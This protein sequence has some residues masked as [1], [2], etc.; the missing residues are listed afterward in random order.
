M[1]KP[2]LPAFLSVQGL[3]LSDEE[4][5]LFAKCN[6][7][8]VCL[9]AKGCANVQNPQQLKKLCQEIKEVIGRD[10]VLIAVDQE[11]GRVRRLVEPEFTPLAEQQK[12]TT[13]DLVRQ[14]AFLAAHDLK[15]CGI[16]IDF[17]P[18]LDICY[19]FTSSVLQGRCFAGNEKQI[20][21]LGQAMVDEFIA[22]GICPCV[23]HLPG[24]GRAQSDPHLELPVINAGLDT[25][26]QDFYPFKQLKNAPMGMVAH[27]LLTQI[28]NLRPSSESPAVIHDIIRTEIGFSGFL[29]SDAIMMRALNGS[30]AERAK[31]TLAAGCD[32]VC[33]GN[34]GFSDNVEL[35]D[36]GLILSDEAAERLSAVQKIIRQPLKHSD[37]EQIKN[38]YCATLKNIISYNSEYDATEVL[39]RI[40]E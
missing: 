39:N 24:H 23:K 9:F 18:V 25:L 22:N 30:I 26:Q 16:N 38:K 7:L 31:R 34:T 10:D 15:N 3:Q 37:Y 32:A 14:H 20:A 36:S 40:R 1:T 35:A 17:A 13:P 29:V 11:G 33:L 21:V 5:R 2:I 27:L 19:K 28:D 12:L 6:P 8:G 4:K